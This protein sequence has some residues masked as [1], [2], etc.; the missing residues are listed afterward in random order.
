MI[1]VKKTIE[2]ITS[3]YPN[4][5]ILIAYNSISGCTYIINS[6]DEELRR[7]CAML[8]SAKNSEIVEYY[9]DITNNQLP[10]KISFMTCTYFVGID[11]SE[12]FHLISVINS[13]KTHTVLSTDKLQQIAGRCRDAEGLLSETI[14]YSTKAV[15]YDIDPNNIENQVLED[16][17]QLSIFGTLYPILQEKFTSNFYLFRE[18]FDSKE[19]IEGTAKRYY[20]TSPVKILR[21]NVIG[22][23]V[24]F[25]FNIDNVRIQVELL[26]T[27]FNQSFTLKDKLVHEGHHVDFQ[28]Y[29]ETTSISDAIIEETDTQLEERNQSQQENII[30]RLQEVSS[31]EERKSL[32]R[33]LHSECTRKNAIF[34]EHFIELQ[35]YVPFNTLIEK[36]PQFDKPKSYNSFYN[37]VLF[38][39]LEDNHSIKGTI[40]R[41]FPLN[42]IFTGNELTDKFNTI[43]S[44]I[45]GYNELSPKQAIPLIKA[46]CALSNRTSKRVNGKPIGAYKIISHNPFDFEAHIEPLQRLSSSQDMRRKFRFP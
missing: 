25:F 13:K 12:R 41:N 4:H 3:T 35:E 19:L 26:K 39:A 15:L 5:K 21:K 14:I 37:Y 28:V 38:W 7:D 31:L 30:S 36:L 23:L 43:Y 33:R 18:E 42:A 24:P 45:L 46:F 10:K 8:C 22:Q 27:L 20:G 34:L 40:Y 29:Q 16:A 2:E 17:Q 44:G 6:L 9:S 32:A 11:I 1:R